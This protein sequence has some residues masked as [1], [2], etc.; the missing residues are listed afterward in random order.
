MNTADTKPDLAPVAAPPSSLGGRSLVVR[1]FGLTD[2][3]KVRPSNEDHF[4]IGELLRKFG[5]EAD[6]ARA[7]LLD[8]LRYFDDECPRECP[9]RRRRDRAARAGMGRSAAFS[10]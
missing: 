8:F 4:L 7:V 9:R 6:N 3:G 2:R 10:D 5:D 1:S